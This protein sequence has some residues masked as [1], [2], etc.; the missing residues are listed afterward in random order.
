MTSTQKR[1]K[2]K[3]QADRKEAV[4]LGLITYDEEQARRY[5]ISIRE[6]QLHKHAGFTTGDMD[7]KFLKKE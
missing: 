5:N 2:R 6:Y 1:A 7:W 3:R 4:R